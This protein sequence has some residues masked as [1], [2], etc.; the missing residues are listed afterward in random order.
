VNRLAHPALAR[1]DTFANRRPDPVLQQIEVVGDPTT[2]PPM[3]AFRPV[4]RYFERPHQ[5]AGA[6]HQRAPRGA[7]AS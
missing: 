3:T 7:C 1:R 5:P 6:A 4:S 2:T